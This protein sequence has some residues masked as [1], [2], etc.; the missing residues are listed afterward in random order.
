MVRFRFLFYGRW[1]DGKRWWGARILALEARR[2]ALRPRK[3]FSALGSEA[4]V[5]R[6]WCNG[7]RLL[8]GCQ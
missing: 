2:G 8:A 5:Q 6:L 7:A 3:A 4:S 1:A